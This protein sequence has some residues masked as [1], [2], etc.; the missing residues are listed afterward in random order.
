MFPEVVSNKTETPLGFVDGTER[1]KENL[2]IHKELEKNQ[3]E[4]DNTL[5]LEVKDNNN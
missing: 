3:I 5:I 2:I 1:K 4:E